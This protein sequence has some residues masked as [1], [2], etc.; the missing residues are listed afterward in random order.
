MATQLVSINNA[1]CQRATG[2][3]QELTSAAYRERG[4][5]TSPSNHQNYAYHRILN[6][7]EPE[8][9]FRQ[10]NGHAKGGKHSST[11][12]QAADKPHQ[13]GFS[14]LASSFRYIIM[15][16]KAFYNGFL[17]DSSNESA[18][19]SGEAPVVEPYFSVPVL[20]NTAPPML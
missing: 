17:G 9:N 16:V 20:P 14:Y 10:D 2:H 15:K 8:T 5:K 6:S 12:S 4:R 13:L 3:K 1:K 19:G 18:M 11:R 7:S